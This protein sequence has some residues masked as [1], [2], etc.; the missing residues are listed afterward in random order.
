MAKRI[1][2]Y[3]SEEQYEVFS[4]LAKDCSA[5]EAE[6]IRAALKNYMLQ[7]GPTI[8]DDFFWPN[9]DPKRGGKRA[10]QGWPK[11]RPRKIGG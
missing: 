1:V 7:I 4:R 2:S 3:L 8:Y 5:D 10:G 11:G 6:I 9:N